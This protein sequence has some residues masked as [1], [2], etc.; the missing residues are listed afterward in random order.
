[1]TQAP[2]TANDVMFQLKEALHALDGARNDSTLSPGVI[3]DLIHEATWAVI[4]AID[5]LRNL[6]TTEVTS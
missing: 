5:G 3:A 4:F 2:S 6:P 1:M